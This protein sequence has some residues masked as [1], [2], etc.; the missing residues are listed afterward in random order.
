MSCKEQ[1]TRG[2]RGIPVYDLIFI[3][4][5]LWSRRHLIPN[6]YIYNPIEGVYMASGTKIN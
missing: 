4:S 1:G 5:I 2:E 6:M 3:L